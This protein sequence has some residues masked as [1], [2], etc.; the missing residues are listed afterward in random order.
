MIRSF[1][2]TTVREVQAPNSDPGLCGM[3]QSPSTSCLVPAP[4]LSTVAIMV[5]PATNGQLH[6]ACVVAAKNRK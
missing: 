4:V 1:S 5:D 6:M 2:R 3:T